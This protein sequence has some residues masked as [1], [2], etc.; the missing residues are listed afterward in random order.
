MN[1]AT[2]GRPVRIRAQLTSWGALFLATGPLLLA[3]TVA[4]PWFTWILFAWAGLGFSHVVLARWNLRGLRLHMQF[5]ESRT[6]EDRAT[7]L[8]LTLRNERRW[9]PAWNLELAVTHPRGRRIEAIVHPAPLDP[10]AAVTVCVNVVPRRF[11]P[12]W[13]RASTLASAFPLA[14]Y[15]LQ[16]E[17]NPIPGSTILVWPRPLRVPVRAAGLREARARGA[18]AGSLPGPEIRPYRTGDPISAICW[19]STARTG[20]PQVR[21]RE[22]LA[23][24]TRILVIDPSRRRWSHIAQFRKMI[25]L[26]SALLEDGHR[27]HTMRTVLIGEQRFDVRTPEQFVAA[28]D[29]LSKLT[30]VRCRPLQPSRREPHLLLVPSGRHG[31]RALTEEGFLTSHAA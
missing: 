31:V 6:R 30:P 1:T 2:P 27:R 9:L 20:T 15:R 28:M 19:K 13:L 8:I 29:V 26:A 4:T 21:P 10:G 25:M 24:R 16:A 18:I 3:G 11:G 12:H 22:P 17:W 23:L 14:L 7:P 5:E